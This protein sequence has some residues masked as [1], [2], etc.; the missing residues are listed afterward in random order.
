[1]YA[2]MASCSSCQQ[3]SP[4]L[5]RPILLCSHSLSPPLLSPPPPSSSSPLLLFLP[6]PLST[7][8]PLPAL[9]QPSSHLT[10][11]S[12]FLFFVCR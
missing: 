9:P 12:F 3:N 6:P 7:S 1:M 2:L 11:L 4:F 8:S 10:F 5:P